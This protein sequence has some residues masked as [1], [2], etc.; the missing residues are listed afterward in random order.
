MIFSEESLCQRW[1]LAQSLDL[2]RLHVKE[3][4]YQFGFLIFAERVQ[5]V[6]TLLIFMPLAIHST[7]QDPFIVAGSFHRCRNTAAH[8]W[9]PGST[10]VVSYTG[11]LYTL[12]C[13]MIRMRHK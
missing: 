8:T 6:L 5:G 3:P 11:V 13:F 4:I 10:R 2:G 7:L 12:A 9:A 1:I